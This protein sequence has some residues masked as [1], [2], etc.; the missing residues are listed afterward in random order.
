M[1]STWRGRRDRRNIDKYPIDSTGG[2]IVRNTVDGY[3]IFIYES[4]FAT[5]IRDS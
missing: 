2:W 3:H 5:E 4:H 1:W